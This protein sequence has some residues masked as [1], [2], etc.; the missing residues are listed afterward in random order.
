[1]GPEA[2]AKK[3]GFNKR[4]VYLAAGGMVVCAALMYA[5]AKTQGVMPMTLDEA[6]K[7]AQQEQHSNKNG[8]GSGSGNGTIKLDG[9]TGLA[10]EGKAVLIDGVEQVPT[11]SDAVPYFPQT[12]HLPSSL[13]EK[14]HLEHHS[15]DTLSVSN[16]KDAGKEEEY[17][18]LGLGVRTVT[19]FSIKVYV[20]G[21]YVATR[22]IPLLQQRLLK[23]AQ[24]G[25]KPDRGV[26][27]G[28][29]GGGASSLATSLLPFERDALKQS[30]LE[31]SEKGEEVWNEVLRHGGVKTAIR[32]VPT[33][34]TDFGHLR[35]AWVRTATNRAKRAQAR[36]SSAAAAT[37]PDSPSPDS[38]DAAGTQMS[39]IPF[40]EYADPNFGASVNDLKAM[41]G[42]GKKSLPKN[43][44][45]Y[46]LRGRLGTLELLVQ[47][48]TTPA[49]RAADLTWIGGVADERIGRVLWQQYLAGKT[50]ASEEA[51]RSII[52][53][54]MEFM[55][56]PT[57]TL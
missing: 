18:L 3:N 5:I 10:T 21:M 11:G 9:P 32:I 8:S 26:G 14:C 41:T 52:E 20:V 48:P 33:R 16:N 13:G 49:N 24:A 12:I 15:G 40:A 1:M 54:M 27:G 29:D 28:G 17:Q 56:R 51:R 42:T 19:F 47:P 4:R 43:Q 34:N 30:L 2:A 45:V 57:G 39:H 37:A 55:A 46:L 53:G 31:P 6:R 23:Q 36:V 22:D 7:K 38:G 35:D 44:I 50:V 25:P